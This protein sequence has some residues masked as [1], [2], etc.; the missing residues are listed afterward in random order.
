M[1]K[2]VLLLT[3]C[4]CLLGIA[5]SASAATGISQLNTYCTVE[6]NGGC[7]VT[8]TATV[9]LE[10]A[11]D[12]LYFPVP[13]EASAVTLNGSRVRAAKD[14]S[15][16]QVDLSRLI[17]KMAGD[18]TFTVHYTLHDVIHTNEAGLL[19]M[20]LPLLCGFAYPV[21]AME[22]SVTLPGATQALPS[23]FSGYHQ[24][25]IEKDLTY[26]TE[27]AT[28]TG[29]AQKA[30]KDH[31]T[32]TM[33]LSVTEDMFPQSIVKNTQFNV[34][35]VAMAVC[36][37]LAL[38]YWLL[39]LLSFPTLP[40]RS[41]DLPQG[42]TPGQLGSI[43]ALRGID[44][45]VQ[46]F[47][48]AQLG[49]L[50]IRMDR[51]K[52][53]RLQKLM[54][55]GNERSEWERRAFQRLFGKN[56]SVDPAGYSFASLW[57]QLASSPAG[58][59]ELIHRR[60]GSGRIFR[61]L[62]A[63]I[64]LFGGAG[65]GIAAAGGAVLQW[66]VIIL[67]S[68]LGLVSGWWIQDWFSGILLRQKDIGFTRLALCCSWLLLGLI[69]GDFLLS[70]QM[71]LGLLVAGLLLFWSGRRT[72]LGKTQREQVFALRRYLTYAD[73]QTLQQLCS[74]DPDYFF[75]MLPAAMALGVDKAFARRFGSLRFSGCPYLRWEIDANMTAPQ[76]CATLRRVA[77]AMDD[78]AKKL[79]MERFLGILHS[80]TRR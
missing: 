31:E 17:G 75:R 3:L 36:A 39:F 63:G 73:R 59:R 69:C 68:V 38:A 18:F 23:F 47:H 76:W 43:L 28:I 51:K 26:K 9:H 80:I 49:Y 21:Q 32:L 42:S 78:R 10:Q 16:R 30:L 12:R 57:Q 4:L 48:W 27:A 14:G 29:A 2:V 50:M 58:I 77:S 25:S 65:L 34:G 24:A 15:F 33:Q 5:V 53:I 54:E 13:A 52:N 79:P 62:A 44:L 20:Q 45:T 37:G 46:V 70:L 7:Q 74:Q 60:S 72:D 22:F 55:M 8:V 66:L 6:T 11:V 61:I 40:R 56:N 67:L 1:R 35:A 64:G 41:T 19:E 71:V